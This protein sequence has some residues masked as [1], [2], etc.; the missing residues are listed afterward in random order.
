MRIATY[1]TRSHPTALQVYEEIVLILG[2]QGE[3][4]GQCL[5]P[6]DATVFAPIDIAWLAFFAKLSLSQDVVFES[7]TA[8]LYDVILFSMVTERAEDFTT[9]IDE[10]CIKSFDQRCSRTDTLVAGR[11]GA[12]LFVPDARTAVPIQR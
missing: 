9:L 8:I 5:P 12:G 6:G 1:L 3:F 11:D 10:V 2:L 4:R 7:F